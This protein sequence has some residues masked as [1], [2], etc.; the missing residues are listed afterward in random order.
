M[1][2]IKNEL[3]KMQDLKYKDFHSKLIPTINPD[4]IIGVRVPKLRRYAKE[5]FKSGE[6][7][8]FINELPHKYY[9]ENNL[10]VFLIEQIC[11]FDEVI[12][13]TE[14]FLPYVDNWATCDM[15][16]PKAFKKNKEKLI[17]RV[18]EWIDSKN[19]YTVRYGIGILL[20]LYLDDCDAEK[21]FE[22]VSK[23]KSDEYYINMM[24]AWYFATALTKQFEKSL[25]YITEMRLDRWVH[26]KAI[27]KAVESKRINPDTKKYLKNLKIRGEE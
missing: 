8:E 26:N 1:C 20:K 16:F 11:D 10:H 25:P 24:I 14:K 9:E 15:F 3:F 6:Y 21:H 27:Q 7:R 2:N 17:K 4:L 23:I 22:R 18:Y 13:E 19:T 5:L 12:K